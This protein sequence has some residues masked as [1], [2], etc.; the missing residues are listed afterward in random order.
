MDNL[1]DSHYLQLPSQ[2]NIYLSARLQKADGSNRIIVG[3]LRRKVFVVEY[4][5]NEEFLEPITTEV[6]FAYISNGAEITSI[7]VFNRSKTMDDFVIGI[8][9]MR[10]T[11]TG[12]SAHLNLYCEYDLE[13]DVELS[14]ETIGQH[15]E[16]LMLDYIPY[17]LHHTQISPH[18]VNGSY[19]NLWLLPGSDNKIHA[20]RGRYHDRNFVEISVG[21]F[22]VE[23]EDVPAIVMC[24]KV[25]YYNNYHH[26]ISSLGCENGQV[27]CAIVECK[28]NHILRSLST[29]YEN[30]ISSVQLFTLK[31]PEIPVDDIEQYIQND[32]LTFLEKN[33]EVNL[34]VTNTLF[35]SEVFMDVLKYDFKNRHCLHESTLYDACLCSVIADVD[36]D[37]NKEII[38]GTYGEELLLFKYVDNETWKM[39]GQKSIPNPVHKLYYVDLTED[40]V[41]E[42]ITVTAKGLHVYQHKLKDVHKLISSRIEKLDK[43]RLEELILKENWS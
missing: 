12:T 26:R 22:F 15:C 19:E 20:Y 24:I 16:S 25:L 37:G 27:R 41:S 2:G 5:C 18:Q 35:H 42:L 43:E 14:L 23:F 28:S 30:P 6:Y 17:G 8:V 31:M 21:D 9:I 13:P 33:P 36:F 29:E 4:R 3:C 32:D 10:N 11:E 39:I 7:D 34:L 38:L 1:I 40:G